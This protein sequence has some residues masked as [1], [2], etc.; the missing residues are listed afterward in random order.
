MFSLVLFLAKD[1]N[2]ICATKRRFI[3]FG[4]V[5]VYPGCFGSIHTEGDFYG[6]SLPCKA[7]TIN[8]S[9]KHLAITW[10]VKEIKHATNTSQLCNW[11]TRV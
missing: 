9:E 5:L 4:N 1:L 8:G 3:W 2:Y 10:L 11:R 7:E 6:S